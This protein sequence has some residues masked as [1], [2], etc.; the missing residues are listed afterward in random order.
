[1]RLGDTQALD[2]KRQALTLMEEAGCDTTQLCGPEEWGKL[3][4]ALAPDY[5]FKIFQFKV[6]TQRL[7]LEPLYKGWG[8]G[9]CLN[10]LYDNQHYDAILSMPGV[11]EHQY[12]CDYCDKGYR[13]IVIIVTKDTEIS[14]T[15]GQSVLIVARFVW[16][17]LLV[18]RTGLLS[19]VLSAMVT[20][21]I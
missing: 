12:Y 2:Q 21:E 4:Q 5:R 20:L 19:I 3:Q 11:T 9:T 13:N 6:N 1:M 16:P 7:Q 10:V 14:K 17:I 15:T 18:L 8:H